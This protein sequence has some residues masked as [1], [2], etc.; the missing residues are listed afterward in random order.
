MTEHASRPRFPLAKLLGITALPIISFL[1]MLLLCALC[2]ASLF[3]GGTASNIS[4][5]FKNICYFSLLCFAVSINLH[6]GRMAFDVGAIIVLSTV[7]GFISGITAGDNVAVAIAVAA[8]CGC[9]LNLFSGM[10]YVLLRLPMMIISLGTTLIYE[11]IAYWIVRQYAYNGNVEALQLKR[12]LTPS[13]CSISAD[14]PAMILISLAATALMVVLFHYTKF[15]YDYR[16]LQSGQRIAVNTGIREIP[17]AFVCY[18]VS[19]LLM[20]V[21]GIV[22]YSYASAVQPTIN[23]GTVSIMFEC[24]CP[25]FFGGFINRFINKSSA[26]FIGVISY[27]LIQIGL[28]QIQIAQN[29]NNYV[30]PLINAAI[31]VIFMICQTNETAIR[32]AA[33]HLLARRCTTSSSYK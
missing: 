28:G 25:L 31:L 19:G 21:A 33:R 30:I 10:L 11:A 22:N 32:N 2:G 7:L 23:F 9:L 12:V 1:V 26:I 17:N 8:V 5:F 14:I 15:G 27:S 16:A 3:V 13:L 4:S 18:A 20:G 6:T 29:W 24:F